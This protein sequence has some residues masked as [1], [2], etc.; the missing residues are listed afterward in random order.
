V[1]AKA[2]ETS[3]ELISKPFFRVGSPRDSTIDR[4]IHRD[5]FFN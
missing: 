5:R 1:R 4:P 2:G 3:P